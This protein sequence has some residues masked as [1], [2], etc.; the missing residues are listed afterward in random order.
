[1]TEIEQLRADIKKRLNSY[2]DL[3]AEHRQIEEE[4]REVEALLG[5]PSSPN[6]DGMPRGSGV[7]RPTENKADVHLALLDRYKAQLDKLAA[8]QVDIENLIES[9]EPTH[10]RLA[11]YRYIDGMT[12]EGVCC[13]MS[14]SWRQTH[15]IHG[16][17]LDKL[18]ADEIEKRETAV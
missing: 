9:L 12:W 13:M 6:M 8:A 7:S 18:V 2:L 16:Q 11:R 17:M 10:R 14:Y 5:A 3:K 4:L 15:R 1:M